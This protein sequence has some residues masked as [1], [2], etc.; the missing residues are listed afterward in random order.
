MAGLYL[1]QV[2]LDPHALRVR[3]IIETE[4]NLKVVDIN[5]STNITSRRVIFKISLSGV[6][7]CLSF[8]LLSGLFSEYLLR[9]CR[10]NVGIRIA[11]SSI[12]SLFN[13]KNGP[14]Q[15]NVLGK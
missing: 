2:S 9:Y 5:N 8:H 15:N 13:C 1:F 6:I 12:Y 14:P 4:G 3:I 7:N 10:F 11:F